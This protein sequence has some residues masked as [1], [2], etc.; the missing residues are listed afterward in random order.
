RIGIVALGYMA[1]VARRQDQIPAA[2]SLVH[3]GRPDVL[4]RRLPAVVHASRDRA[5]G[6]RWRNLE[7]GWAGLP[8]VDEREEIQHVRVGCEGLVL[9]IRQS[10]P[11][12]DLI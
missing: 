8:G 12:G 3:A 6:A 9:P 11:I 7:D 5:V 2:F 1:L 10:R 4:D